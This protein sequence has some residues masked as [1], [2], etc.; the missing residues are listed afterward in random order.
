MIEESI[1]LNHLNDAVNHYKKALKIVEKDIALTRSYLGKN[2]L[3]YGLCGYLRGFYIRNID[4]KHDE[5][6]YITSQLIRFSR[7]YYQKSGI[8]FTYMK[9]DRLRTWTDEDEGNLCHVWAAPPVYSVDDVSV[10]QVI[11]FRIL[12]IS[13]F[14][15]HKKYQQPNFISKS[16]NYLKSW[17]K[18][19]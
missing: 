2:D 6:A 15:M 5:Y 17:I 7:D 4:V 11:E 19:S 9:G 12:I 8:T 16:L 18:K 13:Q 14:L 10:K 3:S 1:L